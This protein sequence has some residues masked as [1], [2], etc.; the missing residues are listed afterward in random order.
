MPAARAT[1]ERARTLYGQLQRASTGPKQ[2]FFRHLSNEIS[3]ALAETEYYAARLD[4]ALAAAHDSID[5]FTSLTLEMPYL[6]DMKAHL[7]ESYLLLA[8]VLQGQGDLAAALAALMPMV[9]GMAGNAGTQAL[10]VT[11]RALAAGEITAGWFRAG[12]GNLGGW[13]DSWTG[14]NNPTNSTNPTQNRPFAGSLDEKGAL[15][16]EVHHRVKNNLQMITSLVSLQASRLSDPEARRLMTQTRLRVG[17]LALVQRLIYEVD[18]SERGSVDTA[19]LFGEL[20]AQVQSNFQSSAISVN[21]H[22]DLGV[23]SGDQ[24]VSA[25]LIVVEAMT[26]ALRHGFPE[27][28]R[29]AILVRLTRDGGDGV[30][31]IIDDGVGALDGEGD[32]GIGLE[33]MLALSVQLEGQFSLIETV[34]GGRTVVVRFPCPEGISA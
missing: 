23:I 11:V 21:C 3:R 12:C 22:S 31:T 19:R 14:G 30:L 26:N 17:A 32:T 7:G 16:K 8:R 5:G 1:F 20:C 18:D 15:L 2:R 27:G 4:A 24:A 25:A 13:G 33:L 10:T 6:A 29:G 34:G 28:R 9:A